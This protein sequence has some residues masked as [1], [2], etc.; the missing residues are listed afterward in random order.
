MALPAALRMRWPPC[1]GLRATEP[2]GVDEEGP[3]DIGTVGL[4]DAPMD[5]LDARLS[6]AF[7]HAGLRVSGDGDRHL[8]GVAVVPGSGSHFIEAAARLADALVTGDLPHHRVVRAAD[9]V[10]SIA[11]PGHIA[12]GR[13][14]LAA[15]V[16]M[17]GQITDARVID[18]TYIDPQ[19]WK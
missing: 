11:D 16:E 10:L 2:F 18:F 6:D 8:K 19:T 12:T 14:G 15:L 7:G 3:G 17:V 9:L 1:W 13:P 4:F 5:A